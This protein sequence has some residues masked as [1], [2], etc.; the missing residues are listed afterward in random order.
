MMTRAVLLI[1]LSVT[2]SGC[3]STVGTIVTAPVKVV[4]QAA[5]WATESEDEADRNRGREIR[6]AEERARKACRREHDDAYDRELC[7]RE[8]MRNQSF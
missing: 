6:R 4:A 1:A 7:F 2:L 8:R 5:D 3:M